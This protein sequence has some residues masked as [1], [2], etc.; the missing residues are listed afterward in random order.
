IS[1]SSQ[2]W[3]PT[4]HTLP[5]R[6]QSQADSS[7]GYSGLEPKGFGQ[8]VGLACALPVL[9]GPDA[10]RRLLDAAATLPLE[11]A[12]QLAERLLVLRLI[13]AHGDAQFAM[14]AGSEGVALRWPFT[15]VLDRIPAESLEQR[16]REMLGSG[17]AEG[18]ARLLDVACQVQATAPPKEGTVLLDLARHDD[19]RVRTLAMRA[20]HN[21]DVPDLAVA[22]ADG[23]WTWRAGL[24][25]HEAAYGSL[26]LLAA[27]RAG[28]PDALE[29]ADP[30]VA[31][32]AY[33]DD[34]D[35]AD[36]FSAWV[37]GQVERLRS[38]PPGGL[39]T[40]SEWADNGPELQRLASERPDDAER[41]LRRLMGS[42]MR[43]SLI[44]FPPFL[45]LLSGLMRADPARAAPLWRE[46][47]AWG[48]EFRPLRETGD[49]AV[50]GAPRRCRPGSAPRGPRPRTG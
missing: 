21:A 7:L 33:R 14:L 34:A 32:Y 37:E 44:A 23:G 5:R 35:R 12:E 6:I 13:D 29:R 36:L 39:S 15:A 50:D 26:L 2:S 27:S 40:A 1:A 49:D 22:F 18:A 45:A 25:R 20:L 48:G 3:T 42:G 41:W 30:Q 24:D 11:A 31:S 4:N 8:V 28:R 46:A 47:I 16:L 9:F 38:P 43:H 19:G 10:R 17:D